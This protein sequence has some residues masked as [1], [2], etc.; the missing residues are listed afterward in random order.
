VG[1]GEER[2]PAQIILQHTQLKTQEGGPEFSSRRA[3]DPGQGPEV[4]HVLRVRRGS[5]ELRGEPL[6][7]LGVDFRK[8][9]RHLVPG[10]RVEG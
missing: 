10:F 5:L 1:N 6:V 4:V 9:E 8:G 7:E 3:G 2:L